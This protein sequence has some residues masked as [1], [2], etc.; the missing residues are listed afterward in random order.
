MQLVNHANAQRQ[1]DE[2][3]EIFKLWTIISSHKIP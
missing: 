1:N 2:K 3:K